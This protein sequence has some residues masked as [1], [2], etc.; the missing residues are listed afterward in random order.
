MIV[1]LPM[2]ALYLLMQFKK[3]VMVTQVLRSLWHLSHTHYSNA[4]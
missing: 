2:R 4:T 1:L 3:L